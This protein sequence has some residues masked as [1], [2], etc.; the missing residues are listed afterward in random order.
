MV[1]AWVLRLLAFFTLGGAVKLLLITSDLH[2]EISHRLLVFLAGLAF[3]ALLWG[4]G[5]MASAV[6]QIARHV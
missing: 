5:E 6:R 2:W 4:A 3:A 1:L